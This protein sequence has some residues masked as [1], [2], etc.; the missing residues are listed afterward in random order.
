MPQHRPRGGGGEE[1]AMSH[2]KNQ[3]SC[4]R[5]FIG[6]SVIPETELTAEFNLKEKCLL[7]RPVNQRV[8]RV[9]VSTSVLEEEI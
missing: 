5:F 1:E 6:C 3:C 8:A 2:S 9:G 4:G 7:K